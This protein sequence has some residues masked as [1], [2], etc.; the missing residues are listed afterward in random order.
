MCNLH[1]FLKP[2][3]S[4]DIYDNS[5]KLGSRASATTFKHRI[6]KHLKNVFLDKGTF[7]GGSAE[8]S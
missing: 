7:W 6:S 2:Y 3:N 5:A 4:R 1:I 8:W